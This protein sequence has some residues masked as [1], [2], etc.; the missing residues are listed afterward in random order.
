MNPESEKLCH[1]SGILLVHN[2][3]AS[4]DLGDISQVESIMTLVWRWLER[5]IEH[6]I[7]DFK[8]CLNQ[9]VDALL[10]IT[11]EV[12]VEGLQDRL[13]DSSNSFE[14]H[15]SVTD[16]V[17]LTLHTL[18]D[19]GTTTTWRSHSG[20]Q[21]DID[22]SIEGLLLRLSVIPAT[23][24]GELTKKLDG[25]LSSKLLLHWHVE[26]IDEDDEPFAVRWSVHSQSTLL[27]LV[28]DEVLGLVGRGL[29]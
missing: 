8:L 9:W 21:D 7:V 4:E 15:L 17:E 28:I 29:R 23:V 18:G 26:V 11:V 19:N 2:H 3:T 24:I 27:T 20:D 13:E 1:S 16:D 14:S 12:L 10:N 22:E 6:I 25:W 5:S